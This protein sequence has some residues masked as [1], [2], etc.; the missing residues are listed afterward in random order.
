MGEYPKLDEYPILSRY[1]KTSL[2]LLEMRET[3]EKKD[4]CWQ[5]ITLT[6]DALKDQQDYNRRFIEARRNSDPNREYS[7]YTFVTAQ[8]FKQYAI[9]CE[10]AGDIPHAIWTCQYAIRLGLTDDGTKGGM[11]GR[12]DKLMRKYNAARKEE[13]N[14]QG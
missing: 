5:L 1:V 13:Q 11:P 2:A 6:P 9:I 10:K 8:P 7:G 14:P 12:L 4:A 3:E